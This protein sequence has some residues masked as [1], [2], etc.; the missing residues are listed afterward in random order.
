MPLYNILLR[1]ISPFHSYLRHMKVP[2]ETDLVLDSALLIGLNTC[3][4]WHYK[5]GRITQQQIESVQSKL[6]AYPDSKLKI[7][8]CHHPFDVIREH[9]EE[10][11]VKQAYPALQQWADA[12]LDLVLAGH[13]HHQFSRN[14]QHR[15]P[16]LPRPIYSCQAGTA[17]SYRVRGGL[18][19]SF[20]QLTLCED[21]TETYIQQWDFIESQNSFTCTGEFF[22]CRNTSSPAISRLDVCRVTMN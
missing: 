19:N 16:E 8:V 7:L 9:D 3:N 6:Q 5:N 1:A 11:I 14:L 13:I 21:K 12:G 4:P 18:P 17:L 22:P 2:L 10:N 20:M 15:Y